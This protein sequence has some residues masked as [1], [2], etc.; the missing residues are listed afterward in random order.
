MEPVLSDT[1]RDQGNV[2][3]CTG[4]RSTQVLFMLTELLCGH[5]FLSDVTRCRKTRVSD[6]TGS[7]VHVKEIIFFF[8]F[9]MLVHMQLHVTAYT[10]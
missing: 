1:P 4:C 5:K 7:T 3:D 9:Q 6:C 10:L 8:F 2:S